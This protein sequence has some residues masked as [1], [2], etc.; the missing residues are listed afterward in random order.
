MVSAGKKNQITYIYLFM[1]FGITLNSN[2][3][4]GKYQVFGELIEG[5]DVLK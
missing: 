1:R 4:D 2:R 3:L 5:E